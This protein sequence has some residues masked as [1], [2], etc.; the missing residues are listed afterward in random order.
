MGYIRFAAAL[1]T[2]VSLLPCQDTA[3]LAVVHRIKHEAF[4]K[5]KSVD[6]LQS[7]TDRYGPR[8]TGSPEYDAAAEWVA[9]QLKSWGL[10]NVQLEKWGPF[11]RSWS[12]K[13]S[14]I[15]MLAPQYAPLSGFPLAWSDSTGG[16]V[17]ADAISAKIRTRDM[18]QFRT[19]LDRIKKQFKGRLKGK[20]VLIS[21]PHQLGLRTEPAAKRY[22]DSELSARAV[23]P[24]P[25]PV[26]E[27]DYSKLAVPENPAER[28]AFLEAAPRGFTRALR[29]KRKELTREL[30]SFFR[31]EGVRAV[32]TTDTRSEGG[33]VFGESVGWWEAKFPSP[34][35]TIA[36]TPEHYNRIARLLEKKTPVTLEF[37]VKADISTDDVQPVNVVA[38]IPGSAKADELVLI[39]AHLD[40][41]IGGTGA[42]DNAV[43]CAAALEAMRILKTLNLKLDRT[44]RLVLWSGEEQGLLGSFE[45]VKAHF[46]DRET[47]QIKPDH[48][49]V[50]AYF[51][52]DNGGGK[53]RGVYLQGNDAARPVFERWLAPFRDLGVTTI[54]IRDTGSTDHV[55]FDEVGLPGFQ[56]IQD[57]LEYMSRTHH[58]SMDTFDRIPPADLMQSSAV[59]ASLL[60]HAANRPEKMPR[61]PLPE[62]QPK[63]TPPSDAGGAAISGAQ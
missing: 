61:K 10:A 17:T 32:I 29:E 46:G 14:S 44:V 21:E 9:T 53:I 35:P 11:G 36:L 19:D 47:M 18:E 54:S 42:T 31:A 20:A 33:A 3:D 12:L 28:R 25:T 26:K 45:Y 51:N 6:I 15:H 16:V 60:Y 34:L 62:P 7:L 58:S 38:E 1:L 50:S 8:L 2:C 13:R 48:Q 4:K 37:E 30:H 59:L 57:P 49:K 39:G 63:W 55:S 22:T 41:W 56:F 23:H 43:G 27:Y 40:S 24:E 5:G 52:L